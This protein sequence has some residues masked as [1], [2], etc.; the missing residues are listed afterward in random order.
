MRIVGG[1]ARLNFVERRLLSCERRQAIGAVPC[2]E[3]VGRIEGHLQRL[4]GLR[5]STNQGNMLLDIE[6]AVTGMALDHVTGM[7]AR[8]ALYQMGIPEE[9][10]PEP[11]Y[12]RPAEGL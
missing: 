5:A 1:E 10:A 4:G 2:A 11:T 3:A 7:A 9:L 8:L 12:G 6:R